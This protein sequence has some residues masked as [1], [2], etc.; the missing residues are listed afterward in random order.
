M[1][2]EEAS[3]IREADQKKRKKWSDAERRIRIKAN[4]IGSP[5]RANRGITTDTLQMMTEVESH[6]LSDGH[7]FP[8]KEIFWI[9]IAEEAIL[10]NISVQSLWSDHM[11]MKVIG[12]NFFVSGY[13]R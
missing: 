10:W 7:M 1:T 11:Q 5:P 9:R 12:K 2:E 4:P 3:K 8:T 6:R 13:F